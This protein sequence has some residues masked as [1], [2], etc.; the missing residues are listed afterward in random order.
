VFPL[1]GERINKEK[2]VFSPIPG[3][4]RSLDVFL[5]QQSGWLFLGDRN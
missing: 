5:R 3:K 1:Q 4:Q 2:I